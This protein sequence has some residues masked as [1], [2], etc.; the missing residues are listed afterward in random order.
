M[1]RTNRFSLPK[2][3]DPYESWPLRTRLFA[4]GEPTEVRVPAYVMLHQF[5]VEDGYLL[6]ADQDCPFE[7]A[8]V[9]ALLSHDLRLLSCRVVGAPYNAHLLTGLEWVNPRE[10]VA[11][12]G[13]DFRMRVTIR[14]R[15]IPILIPRLRIDHL[16]GR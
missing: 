10:L 15:G 9:F 1:I 12:F 3:A 5:Q 7:E 4:D 6:V 2:H 14:R 16:R 13:D 8:T 11:S